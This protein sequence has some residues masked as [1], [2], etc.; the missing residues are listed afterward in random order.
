MDYYPENWV[1]VKITGTDPHY[2]IFAGW[3]GGF[4]SG[5]SWKLNS[6]VTSVTQNAKS[7]FYEFKGASG[8]VY[9]CHP[10]C[11]GISGLYNN[12]VLD[13]ICKRSGGH[14]ERIDEMPNDILTMDWIIK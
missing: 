10:N 12:G 14:A 1:L 13:D 2:R 11:Y 6:G 8:S 7:N 5:D 4:A 3:R 9:H